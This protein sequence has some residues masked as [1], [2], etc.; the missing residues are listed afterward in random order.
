[1]D[2]G[3]AK[4]LSQSSNAKKKEYLIKKQKQKKV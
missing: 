1:M 4:A 2:E 3:E